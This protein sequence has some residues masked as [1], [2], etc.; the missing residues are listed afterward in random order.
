[1]KSAKSKLLHE[2]GGK[3]MLSFAV[4]AAAALNPAH[5]VVVVGHLREQVSDHLEKLSEAVTT[6]VQNDQLGT[7]HAVACGL[8]GLGELQ[9][10]VDALVAEREDLE[11]RW[12]EASELVGD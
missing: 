3:P 4:S 2:V 8:E 10:D 5:L 1:M 9:G 6:A 7:G 11:G 12:L